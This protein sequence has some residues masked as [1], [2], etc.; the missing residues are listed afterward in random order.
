[1]KTSSKLHYLPALLCLVV[2]MVHLVITRN[3]PLNRWK[4]GGFA[5]F[6]SITERILIVTTEQDGHEKQINLK[7]EYSESER[8]VLTSKYLDALKILPTDASF[9][10]LKDLLLDSRFLTSDN[11]YTY[12]AAD[13]SLFSIEKNTITSPDSTLLK[14]LKGKNLFKNLN[15]KVYQTT[16]DL[17]KK[18]IGYELIKEKQYDF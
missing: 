9:E 16:Y 6:S 10:R 11:S 8:E 4:L 15:V 5:M 1:M 17:D 12:V 2:A 3:T 7:H 14:S 13:F 18:T